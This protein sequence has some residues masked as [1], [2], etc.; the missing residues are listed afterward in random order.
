MFLSGI[1]FARAKVA[2]IVKRASLETD[3]FTTA[4]DRLRDKLKELK[5]EPRRSVK[6]SR[7][8]TPASFTLPTLK[9]ITGL[10]RKRNAFGIIASARC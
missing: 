5:G 1:F 4:K 9:T 7:S 8:K 2:G 6:P 10:R 3:V